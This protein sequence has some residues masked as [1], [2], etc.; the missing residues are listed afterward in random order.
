MNE[1]YSLRCYIALFL[2]ALNLYFL[3]GIPILS[4]YLKFK[5]TTDLWRI[6]Y[7]NFLTSTGHSPC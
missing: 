1:F 6:S 2:Q 3:G 7:P 4:G 5:A